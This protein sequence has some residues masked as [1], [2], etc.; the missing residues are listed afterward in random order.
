MGLIDDTTINRHGVCGALLHAR[1]PTGL[2]KHH[3]MVLL[4][5]LRM[6]TW[7]LGKRDDL[8]RPLCRGEGGLGS[9]R[10][11]SPA[12]LRAAATSPPSPACISFNSCES[13]DSAHPC[14]VFS[15]LPPAPSALISLPFILGLLYVEPT[16]THP[17]VSSL[18][19]LGVWL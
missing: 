11:L 4:L 18:Q 16:P 8:L 17:I 2:F 6:R 10:G 9:R 5:Q 19:M 3:E 7:R 15:P 12:E 14:A 13:A 1:H